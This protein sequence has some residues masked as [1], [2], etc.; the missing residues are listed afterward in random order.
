MTSQIIPDFYETATTTDVYTL[1]ERIKIHM[2]LRDSLL[3]YY[4]GFYHL[5]KGKVDIYSKDFK[6]LKSIKVVRLF[7]GLVHEGHIYIGGEK[8]LSILRESDLSEVE[9]IKT[10]CKTT[11]IIGTK[12]WVIA[13]GEDGLAFINKAQM[14]YKQDFFKS[15]NDIQDLGNSL[16]LATEQG[17]RV[18]KLNKLKCKYAEL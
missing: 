15:I 4:L 9:Y 10:D 17:V 3:R 14:N 13:S 11:K 8:R 12:N 18:A 2:V 5:K 7:C 16:L 1:K 6:K